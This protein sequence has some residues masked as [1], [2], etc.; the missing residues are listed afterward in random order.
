MLRSVETQF[1]EIAIQW[2]RDADLTDSDSHR[3]GI[4]DSDRRYASLM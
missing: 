3:L 1:D 2:S 4:G